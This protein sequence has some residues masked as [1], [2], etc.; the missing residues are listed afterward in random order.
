M[1]IY[2]DELAVALKNVMWSECDLFYFISCL[3]IL[4]F[5]SSG[6]AL[7]YGCT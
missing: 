1:F 4:F 2:L 3:T 5:T 7:Q 6:N